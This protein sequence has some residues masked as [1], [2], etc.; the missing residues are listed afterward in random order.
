MSIDTAAL[1]QIHQEALLGGLREYFGPSGLS[2]RVEQAFFGVPRHLFLERYREYHD[3]AWRVVDDASLWRH[4]PAI[5]RNDGLG[6]FGKLG[7]D[8]VATISQPFFV[9]WMLEQLAVEPGMRVLEIGAGSGWNAGLLGW[10]AG[11]TGLVDSVEIIPELAEGARRG[12]SRAGRDNVRVLLGDAGAAL[13]GDRTYDRAVFT[14]GSHDL[15][16]FLYPRVREGGLLQLVLKCPGGGDVLILFRKRGGAFVSEGAR[17]CQ[18]VP[19]TGRGRMKG[20]DPIAREDSAAWNE[21]Q[22]QIVERR[23]FFMGERGDATFLSRTFALRSYLALAEP[24][25]Q[26]FHDAFGLWDGEARSLALVADGSLTIHGGRSA[27]DA[28]DAHVQRWLAL[29]MPSMATLPVQAYPTGAAPSP[30]P[31]EWLL[32]RTA[33]DFLWRAG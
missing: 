1:T 25:M 26:W 27:G 31:G 2:P 15:P 21:V 32:R 5:Y 4:L 10:L 3:P 33:T 30:G 8:V 28:L 17:P 24:R 20:L 13:D 9:L 14:A 22:G 16:D 19:L 6:I 11:P 12:L 18:F 23:P 29:G 7:D